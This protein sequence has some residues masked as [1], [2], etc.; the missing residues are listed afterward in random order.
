MNG[1]RKTLSGTPP[2]LQMYDT[3]L[4][5]RGVVEGSVDIRWDFFIILFTI[6]TW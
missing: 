4:L 6:T 1:L 3:T 2:C 5:I